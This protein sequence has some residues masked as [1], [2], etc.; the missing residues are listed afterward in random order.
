MTKTPRRT[1][2]TAHPGRFVLEFRQ[3]D[4]ITRAISCGAR[5]RLGP[6]L[7]RLHLGTLTEPLPIPMTCRLDATRSERNDWD[8]NDDREECVEE[9]VDDHGRNL[10]L[11]ERGKLPITRITTAAKRF[12]S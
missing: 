10:E 9:P 7:G 3:S 2:Q 5:L 8:A 4:D 12:G 11:V 6:D 1:T